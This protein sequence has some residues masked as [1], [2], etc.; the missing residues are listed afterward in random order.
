M[1]APT[2]GQCWTFARSS[3]TPSNPSRSEHCIAHNPHVDIHLFHLPAAP[4]TARE[5]P[6]FPAAAMNQTRQCKQAC[7]RP[8]ASDPPHLH[9]LLRAS[10]H[11]PLHP[12]AHIEPHV[13]EPCRPAAAPARSASCR[14]GRRRPLRPRTQHHTRS[15][16]GGPGSAAPPEVGSSRA[17][18]QPA[19]RTTRW[20]P[21]EPDTRT[22]ATWRRRGPAAA[23]ATRPLA[24]GAL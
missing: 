2:Q 20:H 1:P 9:P 18:A 21:H 7:R 14:S 3:S 8:E 11:Q 13:E 19:R 17:L 23:A 10:Q 22:P 6:R 5:P 15:G 24:G 16:R 12:R 4:S